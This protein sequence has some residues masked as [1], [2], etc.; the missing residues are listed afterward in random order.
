[1]DQ[2]IE[3]AVVLLRNPLVAAP[4]ICGLILATGFLYTGLLFGWGPEIIRP[5]S[6]QTVRQSVS[7]AKGEVLGSLGTVQ[8]QLAD[9]SKKQGDA[10]KRDHADR[11]ERMEQQLQ[12]WRQQNCKSKGQARNYA[13]LKM[14]DLKD[15]YR[16]LTGNE[17]QMPTCAD[18]GE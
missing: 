17:W 2:L 14:G 16:E 13:W 10:D 12:W 15:R 8:G 7:S 9:I 1:M 3:R 6:A 4:V 11:L 5:A 18:I